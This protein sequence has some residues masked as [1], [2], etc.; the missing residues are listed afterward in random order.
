VQRTSFSRIYQLFMILFVQLFGNGGHVHML[1]ICMQ[2]DM[3]ICYVF[4]CNVRLDTL[5]CHLH[6]PSLFLCFPYI[7]SFSLFIYTVEFVLS[8]YKHLVMLLYSR[9]ISLTRTKHEANYSGSP[10]PAKKR[11]QGGRLVIY[12][13]CRCCFQ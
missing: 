12:C 3:F 5:R 4:V 6:N 2:P 11:G 9:L 13:F 8:E 7:V 10:Y 1:C